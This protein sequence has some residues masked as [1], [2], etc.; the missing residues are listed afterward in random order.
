V[1]IT[2]DAEHG[3][4]PHVA[5]RTNEIAD[6]L[7]THRARATFFLQGRW[8]EA[9][10]E[11]ARRPHRDGHLIGSH[12]HYHARLPLF[13]DAGL[14]TDVDAAETVILDAVG[15]DPR[16]WFRAPFGNG[17]D[18]PQL[19]ATLA[20]LGYRHIGWH[21]SGE[22]WEPGRTAEDVARGVI[23]AVRAHGDGAIVLFHTW[24]DP[25]PGALATILEELAADGARFVGVDELDL[26][27][28]LSPVGDPHP[29][30]AN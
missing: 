18:H 11:L 8:V 25:V 4:R 2:F 10:P 16:P 9:N 22:E 27:A 5:D 26:P 20:D 17:A 23:D 28:D 30:G 15:V 21:A 3:D 29:P 7:A 6:M 12:S 14:R 13:T 24:P 19:I 1:A